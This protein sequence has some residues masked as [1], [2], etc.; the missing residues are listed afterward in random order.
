MF[1]RDCGA[2]Q[3]RDGVC[4]SI[5]YATILVNGEPHPDFSHVFRVGM[6]DYCPI[7]G[8]NTISCECEEGG[9]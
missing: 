4:G 6:I 7:C 5:K 3:D 2:D 9:D 8:R 1:C